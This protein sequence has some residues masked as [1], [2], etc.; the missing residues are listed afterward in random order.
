MKRVSSARLR[1]FQWSAN[2]SPNSIS[3]N[4]VPSRSVSVLQHTRAS[5]VPR[6]RIS[7][8]AGS[9]D[10]VL[11]A[12]SGLLRTSLLGQHGDKGPRALDLAAGAQHA[13]GT[14]RSCQGCKAR[15]CTHTARATGEARAGRAGARQLRC[16]SRRGSCARAGGRVR[17]RR[18]SGGNGSY[19]K[20][21]RQRDA[22]ALHPRSHALDAQLRVFLNR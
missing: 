15:S 10:S 2:A 3:F 19:T 22:H 12:V 5:D 7:L 14:R 20:H 9:P 11:A 18:R 6:R 13:S 17:R 16:C 8:R 4:A 21:V 1:A